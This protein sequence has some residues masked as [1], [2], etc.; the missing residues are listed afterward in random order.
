MG[1]AEADDISEECVK[2]L[3]RLSDFLFV[4]ARHENKQAGI[5][6]ETWKPD[7]S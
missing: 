1:C 3:N 6:E 4:I 7:R 5:R 2:F